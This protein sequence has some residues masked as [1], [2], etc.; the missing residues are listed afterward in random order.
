ML[1]RAASGRAQRPW[2][3]L[4][5]PPLAGPS[6]HASVLLRTEQVQQLKSEVGCRLC[7]LGEVGPG[8]AHLGGG[9]HGSWVGWR[10]HQ[11]EGGGSSLLC[12]AGAGLPAVASGGRPL[13]RAGARRRER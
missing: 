11:G 13:A 3:E 6:V 9:S 8:R 10:Q 5:P 2:A 12:G 4:C 7:G 1:L